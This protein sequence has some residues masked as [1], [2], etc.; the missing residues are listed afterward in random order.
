MGFYSQVKKQVSTREAAE[1]YGIKV[2]RSGMCRCPFHDDRNPSMKVD[3][4]FICFG[5]Q[6]KGDVIRFVSKLFDMPPYDA[7]V[8]LTE[9]MGLT[10]TA[11]SSPGVQPGIRRKAKRERTERQQFEQSV[12]RVYGVYCDYFHLLNQWAEEY[13]P[14]SPTEDFHPLFVEAMH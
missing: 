14:R 7:A 1:H 4:N 2:N 11:E 12:D 6:E 3:R 9:D 8:K 10:V 5:C 13:A